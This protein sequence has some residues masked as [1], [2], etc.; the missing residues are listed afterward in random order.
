[1]S[2]HASLILSPT[3]PGESPWRR[4]MSGGRWLRRYMTFCARGLRRPSDV[5]WFASRDSTELVEGQAADLLSCKIGLTSTH[6]S[7][8]MRKTTEVSWFF[9][10]H[11][12]GSSRSSHSR[13]GNRSADRQYERWD[14]DGSRRRSGVRLPVSARHPDR[15]RP[16]VRWPGRSC[17]CRPQRGGGESAGRLLR[18]Q[19]ADSGGGGFHFG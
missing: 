9:A 16:G 5:I 2:R 19:M 12:A 14:G 11:S 3:Q 8:V 6:R 15:A 18:E 7:G 13:S 4:I 10:V 1:V 17:A